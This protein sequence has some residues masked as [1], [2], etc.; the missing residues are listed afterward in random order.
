MDGEQSIEK[1]FNTLKNNVNKLKLYFE[2]N[3][4][5]ILM[6]IVTFKKIVC[7]ENY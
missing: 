6:I 5:I 1:I 7:Y 3:I 4:R 2:R